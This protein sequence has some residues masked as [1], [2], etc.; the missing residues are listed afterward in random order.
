MAKLSDLTLE[1]F[2]NFVLTICVISAVT[3]ALWN[4]LMPEIFN[5]P[6]ITFLQAMGLRYLAGGIFRTLEKKK[7]D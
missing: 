2:L 7:E 1:K 6:R 3:W 5:L 4:W